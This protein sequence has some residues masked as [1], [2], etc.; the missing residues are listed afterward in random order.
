VEMLKQHERA[1]EG[2]G[3]ATECDALN[4]R[5]GSFQVLS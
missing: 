3:L 5:S 2:E 1:Q 4:E